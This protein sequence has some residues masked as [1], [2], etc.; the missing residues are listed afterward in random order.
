ML[1]PTSTSREPVAPATAMRIERMPAGPPDRRRPAVSA[2]FGGAGSSDPIG[3]RIRRCLGPDP[4]AID[5][6][7]RQ[8]EASVTI[9]QEALLD[10]ELEGRLERHPGNRVS[11]R[12]G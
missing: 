6:L 3:A 1:T 4:V 12:L 9:I 11:L 8:C 2:A 7:V 10:L 5:E